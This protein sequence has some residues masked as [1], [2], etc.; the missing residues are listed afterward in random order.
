VVIINSLEDGKIIW[1][2][3]VVHGDEYV[4]IHAIRWLLTKVVSK[5][6]K[7]AIIAIP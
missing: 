2:Q 5:K 4:D 7:S 3:Y 1:V 6:V